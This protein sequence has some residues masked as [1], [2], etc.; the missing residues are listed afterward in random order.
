MVGVA[1]GHRI[2]VAVEANQRLGVDCRRGFPTGIK[3]R[4]WKRQKRDL[5]F[6]KQHFLRALLA[7]QAALAVLDTLLQEPAVELFQIVNLWHRHQ[8]VEPGVLDHRFH[9]ALLVGS[10]DLAE[11]RVE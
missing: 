8:K 2:V 10:P 3:G 11:V 9:D 6:L 1:H 4:R 5:V 7:P